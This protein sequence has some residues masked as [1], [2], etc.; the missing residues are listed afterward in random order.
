MKLGLFLA[1]GLL[2][3]I[4]H[5]TTS[6]ADEGVVVLEDT[7]SCDFFVV[8]TSNG[9]TL[10][11][12]Y[13]GAIPIWVDD[14]VYGELSSYGFHDIYIEGRGEMHVYIEDYWVDEDKAQRYFYSHC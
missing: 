10:L 1:V 2:A 3:S 12:W 14:R 13:G 7:L 9:Y 8:Q 11:E 4:G 6:L 5:C